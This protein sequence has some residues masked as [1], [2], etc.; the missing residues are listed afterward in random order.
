[1]TS[2]GHGSE[3]G[4]QPPDATRGGERL[5]GKTVLLEVVERP[6]RTW[7]WEPRGREGILPPAHAPRR[8]RRRD[9]QYMAVIAPRGQRAREERVRLK[10]E[11]A[12]GNCE[13][14]EEGG[15]RQ[16]RS[17]R[18][19]SICRDLVGPLGRRASSVDDYAGV[20][21]LEGAHHL[22]LEH[23]CIHQG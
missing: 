21:V 12:Q 23:L 7:R 5:E 18:R 9:P 13:V 10:V 11:A 4:R 17:R 8:D 3:R 14:G 16:R 22:G 19:L 15:R 1:M 2:R 6:V 20:G